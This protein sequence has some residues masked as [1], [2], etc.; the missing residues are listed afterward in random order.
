MIYFIDL[1]IMWDNGYYKIYKR[2]EVPQEYNYRFIG[3]NNYGYSYRLPHSI[4]IPKA[5]YLF[6]VVG[7]TDY[8]NNHDN[9]NSDDDMHTMMVGIGPNLKKGHL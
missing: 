9:S 7:S 6:Q 5:P 3:Y 2:D 4:I 1:Y 8:D